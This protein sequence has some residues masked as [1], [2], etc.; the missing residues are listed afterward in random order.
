MVTPVST[1]DLLLA[2]KSRYGSRGGAGRP[3][4]SASGRR[5]GDYYRA[6]PTSVPSTKLDIGEEL[7]RTQRKYA[8]FSS[9]ASRFP[10][11]QRPATD[12]V[13]NYDKVGPKKDV[14]AEVESSPL[15]YFQLY[16]S[17]ERPKTAPLPAF[18]RVY[19]TNVLHKADIGT[20]IEQSPLAYH[21]VRTA[22]RRFQRP[23]T[24][25]EEHLG[26]GCH[27]VQDRPRSRYPETFISKIARFRSQR[28]VAND[29]IYDLE[30]TSKKS[31]AN[32]TLES[33]QKY[34]VMR[35][36]ASRLGAAPGTEDRGLREALNNIS[37]TYNVDSGPYKTIATEIETEG[38][39]Y[40]YI[41]QST[42]PKI[43][44]T[45]KNVDPALRRVL[46]KLDYYDT[47][48][49]NKQSIATATIRSPHNVSTLQSQTHRDQQD[50]PRTSQALGPG[51]YDYSSADNVVR[52]RTTTLPLSKSE[53]FDKRGQAKALQRSTFDIDREN[54]QWLHKPAYISKTDR[55]A[56]APRSGTDQV[57]DTNTGDK[58]T[59]VKSIQKSSRKYAAVAKHS[60]A[61][62]LI[63]PRVYLAN[64]TR[65][66]HSS[67]TGTKE[68]A[69]SPQ[70]DAEE[71]ENQEPEEKH[72]SSPHGTPSMQSRAPRFQ[73]ERDT[74]LKAALH[75]IDYR[76]VELGS[77]SDNVR[78]SPRTYH[79]M[80][81]LPP[82]RSRKRTG[83]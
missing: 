43:Q 62:R 69:P 38:H 11:I 24:T 48:T 3:P 7:Q 57:Y 59:L 51:S 6:R 83:N 13:Y 5:R 26:P 28:A 29:N 9:H 77:V 15:T 71:Q 2:E 35:S 50:R 12:A 10:K 70:E 33:P 76:A 22:S 58:M 36:R 4:S 66:I 14:G 81:D 56:E 31:V 73:D 47:D 27:G 64:D 44:D 60:K 54:Q 82:T 8:T 67:G 79:Q 61:K 68:S 46:L 18:D 55:S 20:T 78:H 40:A 42:E 17:R 53:R 80:Q 16:S 63:D 37:G 21:N 41:F 72:D 45:A 75:K 74:S 1:E 25:G 32:S 23:Q 30:K 34:S 19:N 65:L 39:P 49:G 52:P